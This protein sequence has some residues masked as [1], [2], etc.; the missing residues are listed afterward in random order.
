LETA[1]LIKKVRKIEIKTKGVTRQLFHGNYS[2]A[3]KARGIAFSEV[4][5]YNIGDEIRTI[6]WN[7]TARSGTPHVKVFDEERELNVFLMVDYS[8]SVEFGTKERLKKELITELSAVLGFSAIQNNDKI[9]IIFFTNKIEKYIPPKKGKFHTLRIIRELIELK[10]ENTKTDL[11]QAFIYA[12]R[13]IK[14]R[15]IIFILSDFNSNNFEKEIKSLSNKHDVIT[16]RIKDER[17]STFPN[18]GI[19]RFVD[20][21]TNKEILIDT[22]SKQTRNL[23]KEYWN[24]KEVSLKKQFRKSKIDEIVIKTNEAYLKPLINFFKARGSKL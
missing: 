24:Q 18:I 3:F 19:I 2:S 5:E 14:K 11:A 1:E 22:S 16:L 10:P 6:D 17:E 12:N 21:E 4:R 9:G 23:L 8:G 13:I 20:K 15:S 7:V